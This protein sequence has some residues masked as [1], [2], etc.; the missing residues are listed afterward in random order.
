MAEPVEYLLH[1][2]ALE[3]NMTCEALVDQVQVSI[4]SLHKLRLVFRKTQASELMICLNLRGPTFGQVRR[5]RV[6][7]SIDESLQDHLRGDCSLIT[8][9]ILYTCSHEEEGG[10]W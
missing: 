7:H 3:L 6:T 1:G 9:D 8:A 4:Q 5:Y 2:C 10:L